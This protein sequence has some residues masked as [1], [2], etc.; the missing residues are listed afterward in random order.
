LLLSA[1]GPAYEQALG[2]AADGQGNLIIVGYFADAICFENFWHWS[3]G[4]SDLFVAKYDPSGKLLWS[5]AG[6]GSN[7]D[8]AQGVAV[9]SGGNIYVTGFFVDNMVFGGIA[10]NSA[11]QGDADLFIAK[12]SP[13]GNLIWVIPGGGTGADLGRGITVAAGGDVVVTGSFSHAANFGGVGAAAHN[14]STDTFVARYSPSGIPRWVAA[15]GGSTNLD[16]GES[17][18]AHQSGDVVVTGYFTN[19]GLFGT[20]SLLGT[21][22]DMFIARYDQNGKLLWIRSAGGAGQDVGTGIV[23]D[24]TGNSFVTGY[25]GGQAPYGASAIFG[26]HVVSNLNG[27]G[28]I[29]VTKVTGAGQFAWAIGAGG[30]GHDDPRGIAL[31]SDG[32]VLIAGTL[33]RISGQQQQVAMFGAT[34]VSYGSNDAIFVAKVFSSGSFAWTKTAD[35]PGYDQAHGITRAPGE[36]VVVVGGFEQATTFDGKTLQATPDYLMDA[37]LWEVATP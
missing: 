7:E 2:V 20:T 24:S 28:E 18:A 14:M 9:D 13:A 31:D 11:G 32:D 30:A 6:G 35:G 22:T 4:A 5:F 34:A 27:Y 19:D 26:Q 23:V 15:G 29:F 36:R 25:Y 33:K 21:A 17:V 10:L 12:F 3:S 16:G 8:R 1:G 37:F